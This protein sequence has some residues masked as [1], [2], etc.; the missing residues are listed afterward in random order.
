[1]D[2]F[3]LEDIDVIS[4][5]L[6]SDRQQDRRE[7]RNVNVYREFAEN[8]PEYLPLKKAMLAVE[9]VIH[10]KD[11][12]SLDFETA[13]KVGSTY[14]PRLFEE[15]GMEEALS[16][17][18]SLLDRMEGMEDPEGYFRDLCHQLKSLLS[19]LSHYET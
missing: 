8:S 5:K 13:V 16:L 17:G 11:R 18:R 14:R 1:M 9:V 12:P 15:F 10:A 4:S 19:F 2:W 6:W 7:G 3:N